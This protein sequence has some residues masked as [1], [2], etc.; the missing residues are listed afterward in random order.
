MGDQPADTVENSIETSVGSDDPIMTSGST[1]RKLRAGP[2]NPWVLAIQKRQRNSGNLI[3]RY[4]ASTSTS[5]VGGIHPLTT[6]APTPTLRGTGRAGGRQGAGPTVPQ[7]LD[8]RGRSSTCKPVNVNSSGPPQYQQN[9]Q[10]QQNQQYHKHLRL[11]E[12]RQLVN[13]STSSRQLINSSGQSQNT[14]S[15]TNRRKTGSWTSSTTSV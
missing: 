4:M 5:G 12:D 7:A 11:E 15:R 2:W 9:L 14:R 10:N 3:P 6:R 13:S 8:G 1:L